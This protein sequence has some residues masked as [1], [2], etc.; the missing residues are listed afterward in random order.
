MKWLDRLLCSHE[1]DYDREDKCACK[2]CDYEY[3]TKIRYPTLARR[4]IDP[5]AHARWKYVR[6]LKSIVKL[7]QADVKDKL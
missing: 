5:V 1:V 6:G 7:L 2:K 4:G 3:P